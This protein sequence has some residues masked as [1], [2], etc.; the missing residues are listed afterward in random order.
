[1]NRIYSAEEFLKIKTSLA[2]FYAFTATIVIGIAFQFI[3]KMDISDILPNIIFGVICSILSFYIYLLNKQRKNASILM[4][5]SAFTS[6][7]IPLLAKLKYAYKFGWT[8]ALLSYNTSTLLVVM[9]F[10]NSLL[11]NKRLMQVIAFSAVS[12][13]TLFVYTAVLNGATYTFD[14]FINGAGMSYGG[15]V[16]PREI[17]FIVATALISLVSLRFIGIIRS[18]AEDV[19]NQKVEI[20]DRI[21]Q[22]QD[23]NSAIKERMTTLFSELESQNNLVV[24]FNE[25]MQNQAATFEE[26][27]ATLE[28]LRTSSEYIHQST[29][30]QIEGNTRLDE[31]IEDFKRIKQETAQN[32]MSSYNRMQ[33]ISG[34]VSTAKEKLANVEDTI[35]TITAQSGEISRT[36]SVITEIAERINLLSL[37]ASIEAARAGDHG[38]GFAVVAAEVGKLASSTTGSIKE[39]NKA[40]DLNSEVTR[41]GA[42]VIKDSSSVIKEMIN[43]ITGNTGSIQ[44]IQ[45]SLTVEESHLSTIIQQMGVNINLARSIGTGTEEQKI[46]IENTSDALEGLNQIVSEMVKEINDLSVSSENIYS[47]ARELLDKACFEPAGV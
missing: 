42:S 34:S 13:W 41:R 3:S 15:V 4:W 29:L 21:N 9:V 11:L 8:F 14:A 17:F 5:I 37:N 46:A 20:E 19:M 33:R 35:S 22:V 16:M 24:R 28:E 47:G 30:E 31:T 44:D 32:L 2:Y 26:I 18:F 1:M 23:L 27:S 43:D 6:I 39:I 12:L 38:K 25:K 36:V 40:L 10:L 45:K 7:S